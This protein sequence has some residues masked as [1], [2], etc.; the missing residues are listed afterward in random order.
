M[1]SRCVTVNLFVA[2]AL[3]V[4][5]PV[6]AASGPVVITNQ[7]QN[8]TVCECGPATF[9]VGVDGTPPFAF[10]WYRFDDATGAGANPI[11]G[12]TQPSYT[13]PYIQRAW[14]GAQFAVVITNANG[15]V[16]SRWATVYV[17]DCPT[18]PRLIAAAGQPDPTRVLLTFAANCGLDAGS[19]RESFNYGISGG[20]NVTAAQ[21]RG[22][23]NVLLT[24]DAPL[25]SGATYSVTASNVSDVMGNIME[26]GNV[27][28]TAS[29]FTPGF[30]R[31][32]VFTNYGPCD[33]LPCFFDPNFPDNPAARFYLTQMNS[34]DAYPDDSHDNYYA[35]LWGYFVPDQTTNYTFYLSSDDAS[36]LWLSTDENPTNKLLLTQEPGCCNPFS[37]HASSPRPLVAGQRY[38]FELMYHEGGGGDYAVASI[39]G[40]NPIPG[41]FLGIYADP[42]VASLSITQHPASTTFY[43]PPVLLSQDFN[44]N[45]GGFT[46]QTPRIYDGPWIYSAANGSW[47]ETGQDSDNGQP[48]TSFLNS[49][50]L[51]VTSPGALMLSLAHRYSFEVGGNILRW[52]GGQ[53]RL[54]VNG[55]AWSAVPPEA[56]TQNGYN[57]AV[58]SN[59]PSELGGQPAFVS[60]SPGYAIA[61]ITSTATLG[62][63]NAGDSVQIQF[64]AANDSSV[65][66][67]VPNWDIDHLE[68]TQGSTPSVT[69]SVGI[70]ASIAGST[71]PVPFYQWYRDSGLGFMPIAGANLASYT[72]IPQLSDHQ[73]RFRVLVSVPGAIETSSEALL[74]AAA[75]DIRR[76]TGGVMLSWP[77]GGT[78]QETT[79]LAAPW[80]D[81][82]N[83]PNPL[84][85]SNGPTRF[86]RVRFPR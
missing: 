67:A 19:A 45:D 27:S 32:D 9:R 78:L 49:P 11:N 21:L 76:S 63:F 72:F 14:S 71:N 84:V 8:I 51:V 4:C 5:V 53:I 18:P 69:F 38:F 65:R 86:F 82:A 7:P 77:A 80:T 44:S 17:A 58:Y 10:Q 68:I 54:S 79:N 1:F 35:R 31:M 36:K 64:M 61:F 42:A 40:A 43:H 83:A 3:A 30:L 20:I 12:A 6:R 74:T 22:G 13:M 46:A 59:S 28:F 34:R 75:I 55:G 66:G 25:A 57:G 33:P 48:N 29:L 85:I 70:V 60:Q 24:T 2:C 15:S 39:D 52:D 81:R 73:A 56:F 62:N 50:T 37:A 41:G 23:T 26:F 16:T 47:R